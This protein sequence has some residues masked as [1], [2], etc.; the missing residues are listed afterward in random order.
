MGRMSELQIE[1]R[2]EQAQIEGQWFELI[3]TLLK[4][5]V[6][7]NVRS[8]PPPEDFD[9]D[10]WEHSNSLPDF[11]FRDQND[12]KTAV[13]IKI[14]RWRNDW[15][16]HV[17]NAIDHLRTIVE[18]LKYEFGI[19]II[20]WDLEL[21]KE[22]ISDLN[23]P[24]NIDIWDISSL[25]ELTKHSPKML[26]TL[27]ELVDETVMHDDFMQSLFPSPSA[28][29]SR[30]SEGEA[31]AQRLSNTCP[32]K[33]GWSEFEELCEASFKLLFSGHITA[34]R[35]Q[36]RTDDGLNRMDLIGRIRT[37]EDSF[38]SSLER[39][40]RTRYVVFEAKNYEDPIKQG[41][42]LTTEKYLFT[43]A[44]RSVAII[45]ARQGA[46]DSAL[47]AAKGSLR[48]HGKLVMILS[49]KEL[50]SLLERL[51]QGD[52]PENELFSKLDQMLMSIGR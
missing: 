8:F 31:L 50:C 29:T 28:H 20:T 13:E 5:P 39:D 27:N 24:D 12:N 3:E 25:R 44:L 30:K 41:Q 37:S 21:N 7:V 1:M 48:E 46:S 17:A 18:D 32:G 35:R 26:E 9:Q 19:L 47:K 51:D 42:V 38:W 2:G 6:R 49:M 23:I 34:W 14:Y 36:N 16:N 22:N 10:A 33:D 11:D 52:S 4:S 40:F 45:V 43:K 15:K